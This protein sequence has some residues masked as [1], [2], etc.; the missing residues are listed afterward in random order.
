MDDTGERRRRLEEAQ[1]LES[2]YDEGGLG[3]REISEDQSILEARCRSMR[4]CARSYLTSRNLGAQRLNRA[5][6]DVVLG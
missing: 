4:I 2:D 6:L 1:S 5:M 3:V